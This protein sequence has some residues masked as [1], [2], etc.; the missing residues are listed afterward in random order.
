M[1]ERFKFCLVCASTTYVLWPDAGC[2]PTRRADPSATPLHRFRCC[3]L[4]CSRL[5]VWWGW[6]RYRAGCFERLSVVLLC[7]F[8]AR[9][10]NGYGARLLG[11]EADAAD[12]CWRDQELLGDDV[13][14]LALAEPARHV[15]V[16]A[17]K[18]GGLSVGNSLF[19]FLRKFSHFRTLY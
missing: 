5:S 19:G 8:C 1:L 13:V 12:G 9:F 10:W 18:N 3:T 17:V 16:E 4:L 14:G 15:L 7:L 6:L 11:V 2:P